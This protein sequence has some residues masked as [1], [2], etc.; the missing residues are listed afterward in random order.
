MMMFSFAIIE[1]Q[2]WYGNHTIGHQFVKA[3]LQSMTTC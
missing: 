3:S 1:V 2:V